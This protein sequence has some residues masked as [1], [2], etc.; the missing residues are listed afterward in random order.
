MDWWFISQQQSI[1]SS[2]HLRPTNWPLSLC[3][4]FDLTFLAPSFNNLVDTIFADGIALG[5][6]VRR[7]QNNF[8]TS[9][10]S[11]DWNAQLAEIIARSA[12]AL[13]A[14]FSP[15]LN[16]ILIPWKT[17]ALRSV[18]F[19]FFRSGSDSETLAVLLDW[20]CFV[21]VT[22]WVRDLETLEPDC[23]IQAASIASAEACLQ[24][25]TLPLRWEMN[26]FLSP[27]IDPANSQATEC[28]QDVRTNQAHLPFANCSLS[29][30][31]LAAGSYSIWSSCL[32][33]FACVIWN[34]TQPLQYAL[35]C[36]KFCSSPQWKN[37]Q[38]AL[39]IAG[40]VARSWDTWKLWSKSNIVFFWILSFFFFEAMGQ[41][42]TLN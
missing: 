19:S 21:I 18:C 42:L 23:S 31:I 40:V 6:A 20:G 11:H 38:S 27:L 9:G 8:L 34:E 32:S 26:T 39:N 28:Q 12:W 2:T 1:N 35:W 3:T 36:T 30:T 25:P 16:G 37:G 24:P 15:W 29:F 33:A 5:A 41:A 7:S 4:I 17:W 14:A 10:S 22:A 13:I